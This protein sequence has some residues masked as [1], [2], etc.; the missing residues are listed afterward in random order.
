MISH[1]CIFMSKFLFKLLV[2]FIICFFKTKDLRVIIW[3]LNFFSYNCKLRI[4][5]IFTFKSKSWW[6][7][8]IWKSS[9]FSFLP[10][11]IKRIINVLWHDIMWFSNCSRR[12]WPSFIWFFF[13]FTNSLSVLDIRWSSF[14][15]ILYLE[16]HS[17]FF[18]TS[19]T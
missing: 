1:Q 2:N 7:R 6:F 5:L 10:K 8:I 13:G 18:L 9:I 17:L 12:S 11:L 14:V 16:T 3:K 15:T 19:S 4:S